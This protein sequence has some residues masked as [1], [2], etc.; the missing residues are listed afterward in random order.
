M[1]HTAMARMHIPAI[2]TI[3]MPK[4]CD[5][6]MRGVTAA[7]HPQRKM[8]SISINAAIDPYDCFIVYESYPTNEEISIRLPSGSAT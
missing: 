1:K 6:E 8:W 2:L 3:F 7:F 5:M 4:G